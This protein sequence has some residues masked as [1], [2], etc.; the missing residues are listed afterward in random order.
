[1][2]FTGNNRLPLLGGIALLL[3]AILVAHWIADWGLVTIHVKDTPLGKVIASISRQGH[4][5]VESS[6]D[7]ATLVTMDVDRVPAVTAL[8]L[9]ASR[10]DAGWRT[11]YLA[12]PTKSVLNAALV[13][14]RGTGKLD[15]WTTYFYPGPPL[16][17]DSGLV[18]DPRNLELKIEGPAQD[19]PSLL[20]EASQKSGV[21]TALP[22]NWSPSVAKLPGE[23]PVRKALPAMVSSAHGKVMEFFLLMQRPHRDWGGG[24]PSTAE[25]GDSNEGPRF[26]GMPPKP[27]WSEQRQLAQIQL[28]PPE[29]RAAAKKELEDR[30][31]FFSQLMQLTPE[32]RRA[33]FMEYMSNPDNMQRM[34]DQ[35]MIRQANQTPDQRI[36]RAVSYLNHKASIQASQ[37]AGAP[38]R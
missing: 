16:G 6:L 11:V 21:M 18:L 13:D 8:D 9:L 4:V 14:L 33:K 38:A 28:L 32:Q 15:D 20:D 23:S 3:F 34:M 27:E 37:G 25:G 24:P 22:K 19:L 35:Q 7:P 1:M 26:G 17:S 5:R 2:S 10:T 12:A 36:N 31:A 30:K 29:Q